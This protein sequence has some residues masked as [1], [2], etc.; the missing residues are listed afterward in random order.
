M[1]DSLD[2]GLDDAERLPEEVDHAVGDPDDAEGEV[3]V[4]PQEIH[5][6]NLFGDLGVSSLFGDLKI[7]TSWL[8][9]SSLLVEEVQR[10]LGKVKPFVCL[11]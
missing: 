2:F 3:L 10:S 8:D 7:V 11:R 1:H 9:S 4:P 5:P 6:G